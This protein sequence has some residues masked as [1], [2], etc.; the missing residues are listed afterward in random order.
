MTTDTQTAAADAAAPRL[1]VEGAVKVFG[2][3]TVL[4]GVDLRVLPGEVHALIGENGAGKSTLTKVIAGVHRPDEGTVTLDGQVMDFRTPGQAVGAGISTVYQELSLVPQLDCASNIALGSE[5]TRALFLKRRHMNA[6]ATS[7]LAEAGSRARP[8]DMVDALSSGERQ[9]I[10]IAKALA[11]DAK[12]VIMDE[13][14]AALSS[15]EIERLHQAVRRLTARGISVIYITHKLVEVFALAD[16]V[17]I[18]RDGH[19][20]TTLTTSETTRDELVSTMLGRTLEN[21]VATSSE[22]RVE[23]LRNLDAS[24]TP[25]LRVRDLSTTGQ[26]SDVSFDVRAGEILGMAGLVGAGRTE[27]VRALVGLEKIT[28]GTVELTGRAIRARS[29]RQAQAAGIVMVPEDRKT[30]GLL[31]DHS[32]ETNVSLPHLAA[33]STAGW[34]DG[35]AVRRMT[36]QCIEN[37]DVRPRRSNIDIGLLSGGNQQKVLIG[38]WLLRDYPVV[39]FDEPSKGVDVGARAGIWQIIRDAAERGA[40]VIVVSSETEE[41]LSL[42]HRILVMRQGRVTAHLD[43]V[44]LTEEEVMKHAF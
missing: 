13:P 27:T 28:A 17:S 2:A 29:P 20:I 3:T 33:L 43:N 42:C 11:S 31:L 16:R 21:E 4:H 30:Q 39:I 7:A 44:E 19:M 24:A 1:L 32:V 14:T 35:R 12:V 8:T 5:Q 36:A 10:E 22:V 23:G 26:V 25:A 15:G 18:M 9:L 37:F 40:A 41:L 6:I 38:R 34:I